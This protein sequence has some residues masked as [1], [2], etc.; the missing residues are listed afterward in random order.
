MK[1][2]IKEDVKQSQTKFQQL[3]FGANTKGIIS[4]GTSSSNNTQ[5]LIFPS[6]LQEDESFEDV[7]NIGD[8]ESP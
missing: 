3:L 5:K 6:E 8:L 1:K 4:E 7:N 2:C